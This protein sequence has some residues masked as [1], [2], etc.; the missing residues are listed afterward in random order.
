MNERALIKYIY[1]KEKL[2]L[3]VSNGGTKE[4]GRRRKKK[5]K[6][7]FTPDLVRESSQLL[8]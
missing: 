5:K 2:E 8:R 4:R 7:I 1:S 3:M 6:K